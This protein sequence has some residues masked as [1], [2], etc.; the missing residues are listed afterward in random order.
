MERYVVVP[1]VKLLNI[2]NRKLEKCKRKCMLP[3]IPYI[4]Y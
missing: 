2:C 4:I 3:D 1:S